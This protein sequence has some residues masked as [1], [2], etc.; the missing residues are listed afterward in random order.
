MFIFSRSFSAV[1][2]GLGTALAIV[3]TSYFLNRPVSTPAAETPATVGS[4]H[5]ETPHAAS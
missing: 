4:T 5:I 2:A 1:G 3:A